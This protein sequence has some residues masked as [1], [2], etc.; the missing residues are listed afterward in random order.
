V[1]EERGPR[2]LLE[3]RLVAQ[4]EVPV[5]DVEERRE[6]V[7]TQV[8]ERRARQ[9]RRRHERHGD[10]DADRGE[11]PPRP[12]E[13]EPEHVEVA[14][15]PELAQQQGRD[16]VARDHEE[17][18]DPE[19]PAGHPAARVRVVEEDRQHRDRAQR[20]DPGHVGKAMAAAPRRALAHRL[21]PKSVRPGRRER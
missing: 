17:D 3:V 14:A 11:Q 4:H 15:A 7:D 1:E 5:V 20:V 13:P 21:H 19:E 12:A 6:R 10:H 9:H 2:E 8:G 16:Q 18:V